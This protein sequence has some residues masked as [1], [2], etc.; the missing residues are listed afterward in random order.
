MPAAGVKGARV[1]P[2]A[3]S[4]TQFSCSTTTT[5]TSTTTST[6]PSRRVCHLGAVFL[7]AVAMSCLLL[8]LQLNAMLM[9]GDAWAQE[10]AQQHQ[11]R[12]VHRSPFALSTLSYPMVTREMMKVAT[13]EVMDFS[14]GLSNPERAERIAKRKQLKVGWIIRKHH[15]DHP[16]PNPSESRSFFISD[17][18]HICAQ[19]L[20]GEG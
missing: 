7:L 3:T 2:V 6:A 13:K 4:P 15:L 18:T 12:K 9:P 10:N 1:K 19:R 14:S 16:N 8:G 5:S 11:Q 17:T 20:R